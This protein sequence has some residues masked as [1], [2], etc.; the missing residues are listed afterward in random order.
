LDKLLSHKKI[1][2]V[3]SFNSP[4]GI[5]FPWTKNFEK[6]RK[7][8]LIAFNSPWGIRF[9]WTNG[10]TFFSNLTGKLSIPLGELDFLGRELT[11]AE[12]DEIFPFNS[13]WGIRFPWTPKKVLTA[14][15]PSDLS[16]PLGE[17]DFLGP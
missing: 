17:L 1:Y 4:W 9:P 5:R 15:F 13:P 7:K 2:I 10:Q 3:R 12:A 6:E 16:I 14:G 8:W 11:P